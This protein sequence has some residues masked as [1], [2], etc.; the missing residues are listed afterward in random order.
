MPSGHARPSAARDH[1]PDGAPGRAPRRSGPRP[2]TLLT[3]PGHQRRRGKHQGGGAVAPPANNC[4]VCGPDNSAG[5]HLVFRLVAGECVARFTP[6][7]QHV[8]YPG[9]VHGGLI[10]SAL[11]DVM[12]NWL[13]L[14]GGRA[15]TARCHVRY[16]RTVAPGETLRLVG[17]PTSRGRKLIKMQGTAIRESD[18]EVVASTRA[19]FV[20]LD[21]GEV[22]AE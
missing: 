22:R 19:T 12:A 8:G 13:Y 1:A 9:V 5:L 15:Y 16:H 20:I 18:N 11:D 4:F 3:Q 14:Q 2:S 7:D 21:A 6:G 17:R 10:Y